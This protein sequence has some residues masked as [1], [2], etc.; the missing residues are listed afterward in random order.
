MIDERARFGEIKKGKKPG[1]QFKVAEELYQSL[2]EDIL[3]APKR[4]EKRGTLPCAF[5]K[6][7]TCCRVCNMGPCQVVEGVEELKGVCG[8]T[9]ATVVAR[10]FARM[11]AAGTSA[12]SDHGRHV[13]KLFYEG[14]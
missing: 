13:V 2:K 6:G 8:A 5:G 10:N 9:A 11:V 1:I 7:G 14:M 4:V 3:T 12:H